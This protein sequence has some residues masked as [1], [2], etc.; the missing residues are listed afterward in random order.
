MILRGLL[1]AIGLVA[2]IASLAIGRP[3]RF[4]LTL[5][6][7]LAVV[8]V[9][10]GTIAADAFPL[11]RRA[12]ACSIVTALCGVALLSRQLEVL[13]AVLIVVLQAVALPVP[14][15][16]RRRSPTTV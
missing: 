9:A 11:R 1:G 5:P 6:C 12:L 14:A 10:A 2:L 15:R 16:W 4:A 8:V 7:G 13:P 3:E